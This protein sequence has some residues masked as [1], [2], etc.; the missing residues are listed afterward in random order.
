MAFG[1]A[2]AV[3][4]TLVLFYAG[5]RGG[6]PPGERRARELR[7]LLLEEELYG[8]ERCLECQAEVEPD[9]ARC[10]VC[11]AQLRE[12]C[13]GCG[14]LLKLHWSACPACSGALG[15]LE[16]LSES[17]HVAVQVAHADLEHPPRPLD[18]PVEDVR[19][20]AA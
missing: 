13:E 6:E 3:P 19:A 2:A 8:G 1:L 18:R 14:G 11:T 16:R 7:R 4:L 12:R 10:P 9:W 20:A 17:E 5:W 15:G